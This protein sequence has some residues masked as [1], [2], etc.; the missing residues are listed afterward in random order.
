MPTILNISRLHQQELSHVL[1][2][3]PDN[4]EEQYVTTG[5]KII[6]PDDTPT[7]MGMIAPRNIT[8]DEYLLEL[9]EFNQKHQMDMMQSSISILE[10]YTKE[11][12]PYP[13]IYNNIRIIDANTVPYDIVNQGYDLI[14]VG[15]SDAGVNIFSKCKYSTDLMD[16]NFEEYSQLQ[17]LSDARDAGI[18]I[19]FT[20]DCLEV[21]S[22]SE[23]YPDDYLALCG[24]FGIS[25]NGVD[26]DNLK[27]I[28][29]IICINSEHSIMTSYFELPEILE[30]QPTHT[31]GLVLKEDANI[32]YENSDL[33]SARSNYYLATYEEEGKGKIVLC[34]LGH[35]FGNFKQFF[36]PS[37][38][39][40][41]ILVNS[42]VWCLQ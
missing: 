5:Y 23:P 31:G 16:S 26:N 10:T 13:D 34:E 35:C 30:V 22:F 6:N 14:V 36:R 29:S 12:I 3:L 33:A 20:H 24:N 40:C 38:E 39:E 42:I 15:I 28:K 19:I 2:M 27:E 1:K 7:E 37:I 25:S 8:V 21:N 18:P 4:M 17:K 41:K 32:I 9:A 11:N